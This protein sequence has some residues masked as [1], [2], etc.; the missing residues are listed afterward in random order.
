[1]NFMRPGDGQIYYLEEEV[2]DGRL[3]R[4]AVLTHT[5]ESRKNLA[6]VGNGVEIDGTH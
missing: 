3:V 2:A 4:I 6:M 5:P 1:M